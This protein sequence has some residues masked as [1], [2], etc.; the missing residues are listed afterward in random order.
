MT[1]WP[2]KLRRY[3]YR[4]QLKAGYKA[5][6]VFENRH[7]TSFGGTVG[8]WASDDRLQQLYQTS[9]CCF[10]PLWTSG[11]SSGSKC[12]DAGGFET[13]LGFGRTELITIAWERSS[14]AAF[15]LFFLI[16][17][18]AAIRSICRFVRGILIRMKQHTSTTIMSNTPET[19]A[20]SIHNRSPGA[21]CWSKTDS[22]LSSLAIC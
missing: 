14:E 20:I 8:G 17:R 3:T 19:R 10:E 16:F 7:Q 2:N 5:W 21:M 6:T 18:F 4:N 15:A 11:C 22:W 12:W 13:V 9:V 1:F